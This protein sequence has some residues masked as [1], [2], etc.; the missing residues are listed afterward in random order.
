[1]H[2]LC[3]YRVGFSIMV[4]Y[5]LIKFTAWQCLTCRG[6]HVM[7]SRTDAAQLHRTACLRMWTAGKRS[8]L[9][10]GQCTG[11]RTAKEAGVQLEQKAP[12]RQ[13]SRRRNPSPG[14]RERPCSK[15]KFTRSPWTCQTHRL[16]PTQSSSWKPSSWALAQMHM[17]LMHAVPPTD[18]Q[19]HGPTW[20]SLW[21]QFDLSAGGADQESA[22]ACTGACSEYP[23]WPHACPTYQLEPRTFI[24]WL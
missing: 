17:F 24:I 20:F 14:T 1:M 8:D 22:Y 16:I 15:Q 9:P 5:T 2:C 10:P 18:I 12:R 23:P 13:G 6:A 11:R 7:R 3:L 21:L 4:A 19:G